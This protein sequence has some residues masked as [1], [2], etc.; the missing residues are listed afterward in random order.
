MQYMH[1]SDCLQVCF[2]SITF[3]LIITSLPKP[4]IGFDLKA[5]PRYYP[6]MS[7]Y[8]T[9]DVQQIFAIS[10]ETVRAWA[11]EFSDY[12]SPLANPGTGRHRLFNLDDMRVF[13]LVSEMKGKG[14]TFA[15][16]HVS[17]AAGERGQF[18][19]GG[20]DQPI[21]NYDT[22]LLLDHARQE[23]DQLKAAQQ[24]SRNENIRLQTRLEEREKR[25]AEL[26]SDHNQRDEVNALHERLEKLQREMGKLE[27]M[28]ELLKSDDD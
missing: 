18:P 15:D 28:I 19:P 5:K 20:A 12:L 24:A 16:I 3:D 27:A 7:D 11:R 21:V 8:K 13:A 22:S 23:I 9:I 10:D 17:L 6:G 4:L 14:L 2:I 26:E 25:I 1:P